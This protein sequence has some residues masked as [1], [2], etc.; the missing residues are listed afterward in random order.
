MSLQLSWDLFVTAFFLIILAYSFIVGKDKTIKI[1]MCIYMSMIASDAIGNILS[2]YI[3]PQIVR[4]IFQNM[5]FSTAMIILKI[6]VFMGIIVLL[7][8]SNNYE[9][10]TKKEKSM[11]IRLGV[12][13]IGGFLCSG[14][15]V[16]TIFFY[17]SGGSF[18][19]LDT[20]TSTAI[21]NAIKNESFLVPKLL[22]NHNWWFA[23]GVIYIILI[24]YFD[25]KS[26]E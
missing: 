2:K 9:V 14:L 4:V 13:G 7:A 21:I 18:V 16:I 25:K 8:V 10:K 22:D 11:L 17:I 5:D 20:T 15:I 24:S 12:I 23:I 6:L 1:I 26:E 19:G 3:S